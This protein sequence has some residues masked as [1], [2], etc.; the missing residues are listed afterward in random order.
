MN[1]IKDF[2]TSFPS[3]TLHAESLLLWRKILSHSFQNYYSHQAQ[4]LQSK[5]TPQG[6]FL[7]RSGFETKGGTGEGSWPPH[8]IKSSPYPSCLT[9][10]LSWLET[11]YWKKVS[12]IA[13]KQILS[14]ILSVL[15]IFRFIIM[16]YLKNFI[17]I[18]SF[19]TKQC[20]TE[21]SPWIIHPLFSILKKFSLYFH[22]VCCPHHV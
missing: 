20:P 12:L 14:K 8:R 2:V 11:K 21:L 17:G 5:H 15:H 1:T 6:V 13:F 16:T 3:L 7:G 4:L 9:P 18:E 19:S 10:S 22:L